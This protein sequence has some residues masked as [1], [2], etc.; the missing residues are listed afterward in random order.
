MVRWGEIC[1]AQGRHDLLSTQG[2][3]KTSIRGN[4]FPEKYQPESFFATLGGQRHTP[5]LDW[6]W[7]ITPSK[8]PPG[9]RFVISAIPPDRV[10][11]DDI[12]SV[13]EFVHSSAPVACARLM[14]P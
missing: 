2:F 3:V 5:W 4:T 1:L 14:K 7:I 6:S 13:W 10:P 8:I 12:Q 11:A 9:G